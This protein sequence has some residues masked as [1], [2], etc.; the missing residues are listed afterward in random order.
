MCKCNSLKQP[1]V[2]FRSARPEKTDQWIL[3]IES[4]P[5]LTPVAN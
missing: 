3:Q 2:P 4:L 5:C 1:V